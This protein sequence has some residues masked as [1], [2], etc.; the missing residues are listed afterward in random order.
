MAFD[1]KKMEQVEQ[2]VRVE[3]ARNPLWKR[4]ALGRWLCPYCGSLAEPIEGAQKYEVVSDH[5]VDACPGWQGFRG[6]YIPLKTLQNKSVSIM[7][8][9]SLATDPA[10]K[11][12]DEWGAWYCPYCVQAQSVPAGPSSERAKRLKGQIKEH[13]QHCQ[14]FAWGDGKPVPLQALRRTVSRANEIKRLQPR[15]LKVLTEDPRWQDMA[16]DGSWICPFCEERIKNIDVSTQ[17]LRRETAPTQVANHLLRYCTV[18]Q[19]VQI[20]GKDGSLKPPE[21]LLKVTDMIQQRRTRATEAPG[22]AKP[23]TE[24][25]GPFKEKSDTGTIPGKLKVGAEGFTLS[26][27]VQE[28]ETT[29]DALSKKGGGSIN[30][31]VEQH[32]FEAA[33]PPAPVPPKAPEPKPA[34][35]E[36]VGEFMSFE[37]EASQVVPVAPQPVAVEPAVVDEKTKIQRQAFARSRRHLLEMT[38]QIP[39][40]EGYEFGAIF[41]PSEN[42]DGDFFYFFELGK[43]R[44][45]IAAW[46]LSVSGMEMVPINQHFL[47]SLSTVLE[48]EQ[49]PRHVL[50]TLN[51]QIFG[52][53]DKETY[54]SILLVVLDTSTSEIVLANAGYQPLL[55]FN[56]FRSPNLMEVRTNGIVLGSDEGALFK[57]LLQEQTIT[58]QQQ[59][60]MVFFSQGVL[61]FQ[62]ETGRTIGIE[63]FKG[64]IEEYGKQDPSYFLS[65][66]EAEYKRMLGGQPQQRDLT[67]VSVKQM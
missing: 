15:V 46:D 27:N 47:E 6:Q 60:L 63:G 37:E 24:V 58:L 17:L 32:H 31:D 39:Q 42:L 44:Y 55:I 40:V 53:T 14:K 26:L 45:A 36:I 19:K 23:A 41:K 48:T 61:E 54:I 62:D 4:S 16:V 50:C 13:L 21:D 51:D 3:L 33:P 29:W 35:N 56:Q 67:I 8:A 52:S 25:R 22:K 28:E 66:T 9:H 57:T 11:T 59:D 20:R 30:S 7:M 64:Y 10:W 49:R 34:E 65:M 2:R 12:F 1:K 43:G 18:Y 38:C 5:L